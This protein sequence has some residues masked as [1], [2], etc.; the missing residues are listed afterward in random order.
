ATSDTLPVA[1]SW[2][3][4]RGVFFTREDSE[5]YTSVAVIGATVADELFPDGQDP[6]GEY[7]LIRNVPFQVIGVLT[8]KGGSSGPGGGDQDDMIYVPLKTGAL[9]LFGEKYARQITV[10]VDDISKISQT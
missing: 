2:P 8:R 4:A 9:R 6:L 10:A 7:V 1:S 5:T 3:L